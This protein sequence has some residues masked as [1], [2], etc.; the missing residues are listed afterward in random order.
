MVYHG[1]PCFINSIMV[2]H[3][4]SCSTMVQHCIMTK[5]VSIWK[6]TMVDHCPTSHCN[7][8]C[9]NMKVNH[10]KAWSTMVACYIMTNVVLYMKIKHD[11]LFFFKVYNF[12]LRF[13]I[14]SIYNIDPLS[15]ALFPW[16]H[17]PLGL[18]FT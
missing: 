6:S 4:Q 12:Y 16:F 5:I 11:Q 14:P 9:L 13:Y 10:G 17:N 3:G 7:K 2:S 15:L 18:L 8:G 1:Q